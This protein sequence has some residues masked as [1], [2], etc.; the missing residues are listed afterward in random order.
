MFLILSSTSDATLYNLGIGFIC[1]KTIFLKSSLASGVLNL[2]APGLLYKCV[3]P[4]D[5]ILIQK[6]I[7]NLNKRTYSNMIYT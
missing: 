5:I 6:Y 3:S 1:S 2:N 7:I 4:Y